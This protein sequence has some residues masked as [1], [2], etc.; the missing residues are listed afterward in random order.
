[1]SML[2]VKQMVLLEEVVSAAKEV[3]QIHSNIEEIKEE[4]KA[5]RLSF[6]DKMDPLTERAKELEAVI[7]DY[8]ISNNMPA[9]KLGSTVFL[10]ETPASYISRE[11]KIEEVLKSLPDGASPDTISKKIITAL[12]KRSVKKTENENEKM[13]KNTA[14]LR[15]VNH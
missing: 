10:L 14:R 1:M 4:I 2:L 12:K 6:K 8:L 7:V 5:A 9:V 11:E 15:I 13:D 3:A